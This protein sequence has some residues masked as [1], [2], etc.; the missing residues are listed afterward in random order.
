MHGRKKSEYKAKQQDPV[1]SSALVKKARQYNTLCDEIISLKNRKSIEDVS[2][3]KSE[4]E[5]IP[6]L[7]KLL[8]VNPDPNYLW[9]YRREI[10]LKNHKEN[11]GDSGI[12]Q[13]ELNLT[14][15]CLKRNPKAYAVW[16]YRKWIIHDWVL[17]SKE[18]L[19]EEEKV[20]SRILLLENELKLCADF[21]ALDE[22]NFHCWNY[23]RYV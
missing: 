10:L 13:K 22:R 9:N 4:A 16:T 18:K 17:S 21:L 19:N 14:V 6:I 5:T 1:I 20:E 2:S 3:S 8:L 12:Y 11:E 23:R 15:S 7:E